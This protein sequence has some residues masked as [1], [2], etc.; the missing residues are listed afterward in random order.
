MATAIL[1]ALFVLGFVAGEQQIYGDSDGSFGVAAY[2]VN[3]SPPSRA[4]A[5]LPH[6]PSDGKAALRTKWCNPPR[7][8]LKAK[9]GI[10]F[11]QR[12]LLDGALLPANTELGHIHTP[13]SFP[14]SPPAPPL[15]AYSNLKNIL[16]FYNITRGSE[17][18]RQVATTLR[19]CRDDQQQEEPHVCAATQQAAMEFAAAALGT[20]PRAARTVIHGRGEPVRYVVAPNGV[21]SI[22]RGKVV[23]CHPL[24]YPADLLYC[25]RPGN[26]QA[27]SVELVGQEDPSLG[28]TAIAVCHEKTDGWALDYFAMLNGTRGE[29][30]CHYMP[31]KYLLWVPAAE[32]KL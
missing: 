24:P 19:F 14:R 25:H 3:W 9:K 29:P 26:V 21:T 15:F 2:E 13:Q 7:Q 8:Q 22:G 18:A 23:P 4:S 1:F 16:A 30:V 10:L 31:E 32:L 11:L 12:N 28:A 20:T 5:T 17:R 27:F 6:S